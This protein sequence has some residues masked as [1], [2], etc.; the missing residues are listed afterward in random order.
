MKMLKHPQDACKNV[1]QSNQNSRTRLHFALQNRCQKCLAK[2]KCQREIRGSLAS[3][4]STAQTS[5]YF[6]SIVDNRQWHAALMHL[7]KL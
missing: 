2:Q 6:S 3:A 1:K 7:H 5:A 4:H